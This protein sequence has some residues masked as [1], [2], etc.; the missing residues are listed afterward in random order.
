MSETNNYLHDKGTMLVFPGGGGAA[1]PLEVGPEGSSL[2]AN[3]NAENGL[4][5]EYQQK[6]PALVGTGAAAT[7]GTFTLSS[8]TH[9][10]INT[11]AA[12][13]GCVIVYTVVTLGTVTEASAFLSTIDNGVGFTPVAS[14]NTDTSVVNWAIVG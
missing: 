6:A 14:Q 2:T 5:V 3:P 13:T 1:E 4:G 8:G 7:K 9:A 10:K 11:T 12:V